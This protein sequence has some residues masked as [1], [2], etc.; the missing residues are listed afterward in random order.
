VRKASVQRSP[1]T[2]PA[3]SL[4]AIK[5]IQ[6]ATE[7]ILAT[8]AMHENLNHMGVRSCGL[9]AILKIK[10]QEGWAASHSLWLELDEQCSA[11]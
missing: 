3:I 2:S 4:D 10:S 11:C 8:N 6:A 1:A 5:R 9:D 7:L